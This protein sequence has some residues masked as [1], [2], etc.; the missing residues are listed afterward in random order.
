MPS[1]FNQQVI[2]EFHANNGKVGGFFEGHDL[3]L[4]TTKGAKSGKPTISPVMYFR[5]GDRIIVIASAGGSDQNPAWYH[6]MLA[7]PEVTAEVGTE[8]G[9]ESFETK[10]AVVTGDERDR[11]YAHMVELAPNFAEYEKKTTRRIPVIA[12]TRTN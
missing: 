10:A 8:D 4:L 3:V 9:T 2:D 6:N 11:F 1:D 7:N 12:L 5:D